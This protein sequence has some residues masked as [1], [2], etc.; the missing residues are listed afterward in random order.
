MQDHIF[1]LEEAGILLSLSA[2]KL[3]IDLLVQ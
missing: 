1:N 3:V 2:V